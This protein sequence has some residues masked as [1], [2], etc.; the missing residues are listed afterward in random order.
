MAVSRDD[1]PVSPGRE[2]IL[3]AGTAPR[4]RAFVGILER[5][6]G[7]GLQGSELPVDALEEGRL[8]CRVRPGIRCGETDDEQGREREKESES[9]RHLRP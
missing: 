7:T 1:L 3:L 5:V 2:G 6:E 4:I 8:Q 9:E